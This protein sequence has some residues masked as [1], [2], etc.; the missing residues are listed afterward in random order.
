MQKEGASK[1]S[2]RYDWHQTSS[3]VVVSVFAKKYDPDRSS[4]ELNPVRLKMNLFF[5]EE[6]ASFKLDVDL[7]GVRVSCLTEMS[8]MSLHRWSLDCGK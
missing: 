1:V 6:E 5:P 3:Y 7:E 8:L 2:C 4:V